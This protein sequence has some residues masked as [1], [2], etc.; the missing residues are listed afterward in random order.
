M[1][2]AYLN[3]K[4]RCPAG[5][6]V[7]VCV[8]CCSVVCCRPVGGRTVAHRN[9]PQLG[10]RT[11][12]RHHR[13]K[14]R[15]YSWTHHVIKYWCFTSRQPG[16]SSHSSTL[17]CF[18]VMVRKRK[19]YLSIY[20]STIFIV[21]R[22][23]MTVECRVVCSQWRLLFVMSAMLCSVW[24]SAVE[25]WRRRLSSAPCHDCHSQ[26]QVSIIRPLC[27]ATTTTQSSPPSLCSASSASVETAAQ[28]RAASAEA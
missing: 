21:G 14:Q 17:R 26:V 27:L 24:C 13:H 28:H 15:W 22:Y 6:I 12:A 4:N 5:G 3:K 10:H 19:I 2:H 7:S 9:I 11:R 8:K 1:K 20:L 23:R 18:H 25:R 16:A